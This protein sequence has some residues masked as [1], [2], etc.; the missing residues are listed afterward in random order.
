MLVPYGPY[1]SK[2]EKS[3]YDYYEGTTGAQHNIAY[4]IT[5][6]LEYC[7]ILQNKRV[8]LFESIRPQMYR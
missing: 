6:P 7:R 4:T 2:H 5:L 3:E 8:S 1:R